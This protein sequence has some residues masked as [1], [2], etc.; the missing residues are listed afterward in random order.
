[1]Y[2][3]P[4]CLISSADTVLSEV[5][6]EMWE[7]GDKPDGAKKK[8]SSQRE[9]TNC[10]QRVKVDS[11]FTAVCSPDSLFKT[12]TILSPLPVVPPLDSHIP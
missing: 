1:M 7:Q 5:I 3:L 2:F 12:R 10:V 11:V 4:S 8:T 6:Y 9:K